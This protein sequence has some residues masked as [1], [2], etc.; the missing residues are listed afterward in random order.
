MA[1][2]FSPVLLIFFSTGIL[3]LANDPCSERSKPSVNCSISRLFVT[4]GSPAEI[5]FEGFEHLLEHVH[6]ADYIFNHTLTSHKDNSTK[7]FLFR[8]LTHNHSPPWP[9][10]ETGDEVEEEAEEEVRCCPCPRDRNKEDITRHKK[11]KHKSKRRYKRETGES[12]DIPEPDEKCFTPS[13]ILASVQLSVDDR[14]TP[15]TFK[16]LCPVILDQIDRGTCLSKPSFSRPKGS[17]KSHSGEEEEEAS[18]I[19]V[20]PL[21]GMF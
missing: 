1:N 7:R 14:I 16:D 17:K 3:G 2:L 21:Y 10:Q 13:E 20:P 9:I 18:G 4:Y 11:H 6:A 12:L 5:N 8:H 19:T 15:Q